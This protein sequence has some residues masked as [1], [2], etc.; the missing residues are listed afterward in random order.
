MSEE[1]KTE[2]SPELVRVF[3][4]GQHTFT[5]DHYTL[6]PGSFADVPSKVAKLWCSFTQFGNYEVVLGSALPSNVS[7]APAVDPQVLKDKE[8]AE[9]KN[10][11]RAKQVE[12]LKKLLAMAQQGRPTSSKAKVFGDN[13]QVLN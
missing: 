7:S 12:E 5:H 11:E 6:K 10:A 9:A 2:E 8:A 13:S 1:I 3:N 4:R